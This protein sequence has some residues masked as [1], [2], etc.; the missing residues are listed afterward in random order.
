MSVYKSKRSPYYSFDFELYGVRF[1]GSTKCRSKRE[2][3][4]FEKERRVEAQRAG[5]DAHHSTNSPMTVNVGFDRFWVE[6]GKNYKGNARETFFTSLKWL[7]HQLGKNTLLRDIGPLK[8]TDAIAA[9]LAVKI[10]NAKDERS[11]K[12]ATVNRTVIEPLRA[13]LNRAR[14]NWEQKVQEINWKD[15]VLTEPKERGRELTGE[16]E[17]RIFASLREDHH[18][19]VFFSIV[20]G[21]RLHECVNLR[22]ADIDWGNLTIAVVGKGEKADVQP[23]TPD[24]RDFLWLWRGQHPEKVFTYVAEQNRPQQGRV[25]GQRYPVT[26]YGLSTAWRRAKLGAKLIDYRFHDNRHTAATRFLRA[27]G[28]LK[29]CQMFLRHENI[30][31]TM[32][33]AHA[34]RDDLRKALN[35]VAESRKKPRKVGMKGKKRSKAGRN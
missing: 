8:V 34:S 33:Y 28:N 6:K 4:Q 27:T 20:S 21:F 19:I 11:V 1:H 25:A 10:K 12:N 17:E 16:E 9:R 29:L 24:I 32:K 23:I 7:S 22:W 35:L 18:P 26:Y 14:K 13:V 15:F 3:E 5:R 2:A 30:T 31:T